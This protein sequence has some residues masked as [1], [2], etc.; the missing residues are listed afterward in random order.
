M[1]H[2]NLGLF[3]SLVAS[4]FVGV[5]SAQTPPPAAQHDARVA[6][7]RTQE[8]AH[9]TSWSLSAGGTLNTGNTRTFAANV[10]SRFQLTRGFNVF[11]TELSFTYGLASLRDS[12]TGAYSDW[13]PNARNLFGSARYDRFLTEDDALFVRAVGRNDPFAGL[14]LRFQAQLGYARNFYSAEKRRIWGEVGYDF[15]FDVFSKPQTNA[16]MTTY[17]TLDQHSARLFFGYDN[18]FNE[19]VQVVLGLEG[20]IDLVNIDNL[21]I[22]SINELNL[23]LTDSFKLGLRFNLLFDNVPAQDKQKLDTTTVVNIIYNLI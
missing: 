15:T 8:D 7:T 18:R 6:A 4:L 21:R 1:K 22:N 20:L 2:F 3:V 12:M 14:D 17:D 10:G 16:D 13:T 11:L 23:Q 19:I 5:A 9:E